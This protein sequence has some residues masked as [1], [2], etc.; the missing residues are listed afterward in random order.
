MSAIMNFRNKLKTGSIC[1][2]SSITLSDP[3]VTDI[4]ADSVD[5]LWLE[6]EHCAMSP[7]IIYGHLLAARAKKI[8]VF[9][10]LGDNQVHLIKHVLDGGA[11][12]IIIPQVRNAGEVKKLVSECRYPPEGRRGFGPRIPTNYFRNDGREYAVWANSNIFVSV[13]IE[14][15][16]AL[17]SLDDILKVHGLDSVIIGPWDLSGSLGLL[18][19]I[20]S[21]VVR[22]AMDTIIEKT[23]QAGLVM[24]AASAPNADAACD[25]IRRGVQCLVVGNDF[26]Y[27]INHIDQLTSNIKKK[28]NSTFTFFS[29]RYSE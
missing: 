25:L 26:N 1:I 19:E 5:F 20:D 12:G 18:G 4:L 7:E 6:L 23:K 22:N 8:P 15:K 17:D 16:E 24:S 10:R 27:M 11:E 9:V 3:L 29:Q 2:G 13:M 28:M 21:P 14:N